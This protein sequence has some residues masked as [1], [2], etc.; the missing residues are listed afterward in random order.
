MN[1]E[2][3][4]S[5]A[6]LLTLFVIL[7]ASCFAQTPSEDALPEAP[8][9]QPSVVAT[10]P[11][12]PPMTRPAAGFFTF[13]KSYL[14]PPLRTNKQVLTS[15]L[16]LIMHGM[17]LASLAVDKWRLPDAREHWAVAGITALD[18]LMDR[19]FTR[20]YMVAPPIYGIQH[21]VRDALHKGSK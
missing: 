2:D 17:L 4:R 20:A 12:P 8:Q 9:P 15:K 7:A 1:G 10:S 19:F 6:L 11:T 16:F 13:R 5:H 18:Y 14:D 3:M 21:Y